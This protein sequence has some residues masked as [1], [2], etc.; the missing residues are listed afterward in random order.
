MARNEPEPFQVLCPLCGHEVQVGANG[1]LCQ[2]C[3][4]QL[5]VFPDPVGAN[6]FAE[7]SKSRGESA[8]WTQALHA[9]YWIVG[10]KSGPELPSFRRAG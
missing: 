9:E 4:A 5:E 3:G 2:F 1:D 7:S 8:R 10:H 6:Q